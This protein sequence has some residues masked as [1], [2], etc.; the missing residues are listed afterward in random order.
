LDVLTKV[1]F[2]EWASPSCGVPKAGGLIRFVTDFCHVNKYIVRHP[3]PT[4]PV[5]HI[6]RTQQGFM[7]IAVPGTRCEYGILDDSSCRTFSKDLHYYLP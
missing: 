4:P 6:L 5:P 3:Y 7:F 2:S 1:N